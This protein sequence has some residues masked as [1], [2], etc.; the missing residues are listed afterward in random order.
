MLLLLLDQWLDRRASSITIR[1]ILSA[2]GV[3]ASLVKAG[4]AFSC[5]AIRRRPLE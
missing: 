3:L 5:A 4:L 1:N 2:M